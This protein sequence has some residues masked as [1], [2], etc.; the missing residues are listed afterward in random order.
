MKIKVFALIF[1]TSCPPGKT[2]KAP[3]DQEYD[4]EFYTDD[5]RG[6]DEFSDHV[7]NDVTED[8]S[9]DSK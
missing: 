9:E 6:D 5:P 2:Q 3:R 8:P 4:Q 1:L 7:K